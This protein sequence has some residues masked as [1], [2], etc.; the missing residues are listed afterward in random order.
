MTL[1]ELKKYVPITKI[2]GITNIPNK[3]E[4][5]VKSPFREER[6]P[7]FKINILKNIWYDFGLGEGGSVLDLI[8]KLKNCSAKEAVKILKEFA[9]TDG[10]S[11]S[12]FSFSPASTTLRTEETESKIKIK[13]VSELKNRALL[14]YLQSRKIDVNIAKKYL[15]EIYYYARNKHYFGIAFE[16]DSGGFEVRNRYFKG[17]ICKKDIT[18]I[19]K[20]SD[21]VAIFEGF[22]DFLS[23]LTYYEKNDVESDVIILN[24]LALLLKVDLSKYK[25]INLF[26]DN[27]EAGESATFEIIRKYSENAKVKNYSFL[28]KSCKDFNEF[29]QIK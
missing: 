5:F 13:K 14:E 24:T 20:N 23:A 15:K 28:Y 11:P 10:T 8:I 6:T 12:S 16:N 3:S 1:Q 17:C 19:S 22:M 4:F 26:L 25:K 9:D 21:K 29:L 18:T 2:L 7:S 27:D